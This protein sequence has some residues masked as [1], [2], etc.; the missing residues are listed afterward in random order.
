M[1][2]KSYS[3]APEKEITTLKKTTLKQRT[4]KQVA[5]EAQ[6]KSQY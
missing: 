5:A 3:K 1:R 6:I 2:N 4:V